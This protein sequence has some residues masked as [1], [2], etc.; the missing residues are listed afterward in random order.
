[1]AFLNVLGAAQAGRAITVWLLPLA[2]LP[3]GVGPVAR[4]ASSTL[5]S[6]QGLVFSMLTLELEP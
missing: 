4:T 5:G 2:S 3:R 6:V 1:M